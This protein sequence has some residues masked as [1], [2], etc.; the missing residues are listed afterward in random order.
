MSIQLFH[1]TNHHY[2]KAFVTSQYTCDTRRFL[3]PIT[4]NHLG[5]T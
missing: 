4:I 5:S 1:N 3:H 2:S